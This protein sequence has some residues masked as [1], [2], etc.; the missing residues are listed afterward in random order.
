ME[1]KKLKEGEKVNVAMHGEHVVINTEM[2]HYEVE[3]KCESEDAG[4][5]VENPSGGGNGLGHTEIKYKN[6]SIKAPSYFSGCTVSSV[7]S[8]PSKMELISDE[9]KGEV[10]LTPAEGTKFAVFTFAGCTHSGLD[11]G[12]D[13][14]GYDYG[15]FNNT[16]SRLEFTKRTSNPMQFS[17]E[18]AAWITT[19]GVTTEGGGYIKAAE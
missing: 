3:I 14:T 11:V 15:L 19:L 4:S 2:I 8:Y 7:V 6:C 1:S 16:A 18:E 13:L 17:G 5:W 10:K 9:G 12:H